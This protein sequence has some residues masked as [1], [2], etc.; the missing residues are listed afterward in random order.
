MTMSTTDNDRSELTPR[1]PSRHSNNLSIFNRP[2]SPLKQEVFASPVFGSP[3]PTYYHDSPILSHGSR[4]LDP[5][6]RWTVLAREA[7][8]DEISLLSITSEEKGYYSA[9]LP[10]DTVAGPVKVDSRAS[11]QISGFDENAFVEYDDSGLQDRREPSIGPD[12]EIED[13]QPSPAP[14]TQFHSPTSPPTRFD[15]AG[16]TQIPTLDPPPYVSFPSSI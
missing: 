13:F 2:G 11:S 7:E 9:L 8:A 14:F 5:A 16:F 1:Q 12:C 10:D 3:E 4:V 15:P 6:Q